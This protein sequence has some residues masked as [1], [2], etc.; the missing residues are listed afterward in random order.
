MRNVRSLLAW[1]LYVFPLFLIPLHFPDR[2]PPG[3]RWRWVNLLAAGMVLFLMVLVT[4]GEKIGPFSERWA[5][6]NPIG[7]VPNSIFDGPFIFFLD[8]RSIW[9]RP[10]PGHGNAVK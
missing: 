4:F 1:L 5:L 8:G 10:D 2:K 6:P 3:R 7:F 9:L